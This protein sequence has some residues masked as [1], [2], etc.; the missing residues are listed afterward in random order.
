MTAQWWITGTPCSAAC[1]VE[2]GVPVLL[3]LAICHIQIM[4]GVEDARDCI[5]CEV[6]Q[7]KGKTQVLDWACAAKP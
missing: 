4:A 3:L 1:W 5:S 2:E 6:R 7:W